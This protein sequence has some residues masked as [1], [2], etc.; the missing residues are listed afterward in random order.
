MPRASHASI[1]G[2]AIIL[3]L[4]VAIVL[5][6]SLRPAPEPQVAQPLPP[7]EVST[8]E[9]AFDAS[10]LLDRTAPV[11]VEYEGSEDWVTLA[12]PWDT[13]F[14]VATPKAI[15]WRMSEQESDHTT[16]DAN[17][18]G[19]ETTGP[20]FLALV[21]TTEPG[22]RDGYW[23]DVVY[24]LDLTADACNKLPEASDPSAGW[25]LNWIESCNT[26]TNA[27]G[28]LVIHLSGEWGGFRDA[29]AWINVY[30]VPSARE[31]IR[32]AVLSDERFMDERALESFV[33]QGGLDITW[34]RNTVRTMAETFWFVE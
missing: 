7:E 27:N 2:V 15:P 16:F 21:P 8:P 13:G 9:P 31:G 30:V 3:I 5:F 20:I 19:G 10:V 4:A 14:N 11:V 24:K 26:F 6:V 28:Q 18:Y 22:A 29:P 33:A 1:V 34:L 32:A 25:Q 17:I 12:S 23:G